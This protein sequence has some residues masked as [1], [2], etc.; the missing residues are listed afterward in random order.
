MGRFGLSLVEAESRTTHGHEGVAAVGQIKAG[1][2]GEHDGVASAIEAAQIV[3]SER[4]LAWFER[5][6]TSLLPL[7]AVAFR[8]HRLRESLASDLDTEAS[9]ALGIA[10]GRRPVERAHKDGI[11]ALFGYIH[12]GDGIGHR[13]PHAMSHE[14]GRTHEI[15]K[16]L[17]DD[18]SAFVGKRFGLNPDLGG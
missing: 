3:K 4:L 2:G 9:G 1:V 17:V 8:A 14:I 11:G 7:P 6:A 16:L 18:P 15:H 13:A 5:D 10:P 12:R